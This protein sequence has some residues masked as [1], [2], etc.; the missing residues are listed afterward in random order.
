MQ[1]VLGS[2]V[3]DGG[4]RVGLLAGFELEPTDLRIRRV[5]FSPDG[6]LGPQVRSQPLDA[7]AAVHDDGE[8]ELKADFSMAPMPVV[9][10]VVL[11]SRSTRLR[12]GA[13]IVGR[14]SG[15]EVGA[16]DRRIV[17]VFGRPHW[18]SRRFTFA[19]EQLDCSTPGEIRSGP[20]S[21][22]RVA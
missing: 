19:A 15:I 11:L 21:G 3:R 9:R 8:I 14:L 5:I 13:S 16:A 17:S 7:I 22:T 20:P 12:R 18:W 2:H 1:L 4:R 6:E 10:D